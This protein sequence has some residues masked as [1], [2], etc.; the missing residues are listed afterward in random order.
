M[1]LHEAEL[2]ARQMVNEALTEKQAIEQSLAKVKAAEQDCRSGSGRCSRTICD[3]SMMR[4]SRR[5]L[6][7]TTRPARSRPTRRG[8]QG[9]DRPGGGPPSPRA[10]RRSRRAR[11][12]ASSSSAVADKCR[13]R[14]R[15]RRLP[16]CRRRAIRR[17][18]R[19]AAPAFPRCP[20]PCCNATRPEPRD[21]RRARA[22]AHRL[23]RA[24]TARRCRQRGE[25]DE[26]KW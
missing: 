6:P 18:S 13:W 4:R 1:V 15:P 7:R 25:R 26:F 11:G 9:G 8:D 10:A 3:I 2:K 12:G 24:T 16:A 20:W 5:G 19:T 21:A 23:A 22:A 14:T 17:P